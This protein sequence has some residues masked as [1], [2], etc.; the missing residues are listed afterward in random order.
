MGRRGTS[1]VLFLAMLPVLAFGFPWSQG[2]QWKYHVELVYTTPPFRTEFDLV[3]RV[4]EA[5]HQEMG[6]LLWTVWICA[7]EMTKNGSKTQETIEYYV[8]PQTIAVRRWPLPAIF[9]SS[10]EQY[11]LLLSFATVGIPNLGEPTSAQEREHPI[12]K[13]GE[14]VGKAKLVVSLTELGAETLDWH[15]QKL[16]A[17]VFEYRA[18]Y[19]MQYETNSFGSGEKWSHWGKMWVASE[20]EIWLIIEGAIAENGE[21]VREEYRITLVDGP[22][23][24]G[25]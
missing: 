19:R 1:F 16:E 20:S 5:K 13:D 12:Y 6:E 24:S 17:K 22:I 18:D 14:L 3:I 7:V 11:R 4:G 8:P 23:G 9:A 10:T 2:L 21:T 15:G 25:R